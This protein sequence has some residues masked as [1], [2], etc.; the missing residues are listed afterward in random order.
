MLFHFNLF[1]IAFQFRT[2]G[3]EGSEIKRKVAIGQNFDFII[4]KSFFGIML[5]IK[6]LRKPLD[7]KINA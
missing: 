6:F 4:K 3:S 5:E 7:L 2:E 1:Y